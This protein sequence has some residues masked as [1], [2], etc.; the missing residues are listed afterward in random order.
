MF[1]KILV[2]QWFL[3]EIKE[4]SSLQHPMTNGWLWTRESPK[5]CE[6]KNW[7][8]L[9]PDTTYLTDSE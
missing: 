8:A 9:V 6:K 4:N 5:K 1:F 3:S 7:F 2:S